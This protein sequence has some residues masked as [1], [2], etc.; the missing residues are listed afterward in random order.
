MTPYFKNGSATLFLGDAREVLPSIDEVSLLLTDPPYGIGFKSNHGGGARFGA[1]QGDGKHEHDGV[2]DIIA[3]AVRKLRNSRHAYLFG[4]FTTQGMAEVGLTSGC[5]L[6]WDKQYMAMDDLNIPWSKQHERI[7]FATKEGK[8]N[9]SKG[10]GRLSAR[11]RKGSVLRCLRFSGPGVKRHPT[12]KP[13]YILRQMIESSSLMDDLVLDP[14]AGS[15]LVAAVMESRKAIGIE[16]DERY[17]EV[18][19][20]RLLSVSEAHE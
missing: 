17:C 2:L 19:A 3:M 16:I 20:K 15:T 11:M 10:Y 9:R 1:I 5:E 6:I 14:F 18:A 8:A 7:T 13:T 4:P 12:E